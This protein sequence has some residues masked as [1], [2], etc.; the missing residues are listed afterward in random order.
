MTK[1]EEINIKLAYKKARQ[2]NTGE[3]LLVNVHIIVL[4]CNYTYKKSLNL[5]HN[6]GYKR[7]LL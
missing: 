6:N 1:E 5:A 4:R 3:M 7:R 2:F